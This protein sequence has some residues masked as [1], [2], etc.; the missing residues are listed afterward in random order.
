MEWKRAKTIII[1]AL[2]ITNV[3]LFSLFIKER[4]IEKEFIER[5]ISFSNSVK[6][7]LKEYGIQVECDIPV[8]EIPIRVVT[9]TYESYDGEKIARELFSEY[10][11]TK[12]DNGP[13]YEQ[14]D[15]VLSINNNKQIRYERYGFSD[16][17][18]ENLKDAK[19]YA[20]DFID[21]LDFENDYVLSYVKKEN[22]GFYLSYSKKYNGT[23]LERCEMNFQIDALGVKNFNRYWLKPTKEVKGTRN[24]RSA[25]KALL[26]LLNEEKAIG[27]KVINIEPAFYFNPNLLSESGVENT[28][29]AQAI[30]SWRIQMDDGKV[31]FVEE[32]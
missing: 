4:K 13:I 14:K 15:A 9:V 1:F 29:R 17:K 22:N 2:I 10:I 5:E 32:Y 21:N 11:I 7:T 26:T 18:L 20:E 30:M 27:R 6:E 24:I 28:E 25:S 8:D 23:L 19:K 12:T 3:V 16:K 31:F